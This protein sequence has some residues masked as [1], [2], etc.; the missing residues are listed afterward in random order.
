LNCGGIEVHTIVGANVLILEN[1]PSVA[2]DT[3]RYFSGMGAIIL[4][5]VQSVQLA[6]PLVEIADAA[7]LDIDLDETLVFAIADRLA[8]RSVPFVFFSRSDGNLVPHRLSYAARLPKLPT[9]PLAVE[10]L[11][12]ESRRRNEGDCEPEDAISLLPKLRLAAHLMLPDPGAADRMVELTLQC[13]IREV[14]SKPRDLSVERWLNSLLNRNVQR[15]AN[16]LH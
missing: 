10:A 8:E 5:P 2:E 4:G 6:E 3:A 9:H 14:T 13:A 1:S 11:Y 15:A 12:A 16:S 7:V